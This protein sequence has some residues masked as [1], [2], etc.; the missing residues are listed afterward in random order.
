MILQVCYNLPEG[1][2]ESQTVDLLL[3]N[4]VMN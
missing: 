1:V 3:G 2:P 4:L